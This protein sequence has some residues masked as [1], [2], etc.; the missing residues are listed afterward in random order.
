MHFRQ[1]NQVVY[2]DCCSQLYSKQEGGRRSKQAARYLSWEA[3]YRGIRGSLPATVL[4][5]LGESLTPLERTAP[6][7]AISVPLIW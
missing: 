2:R 1:Q 3:R 5:D 6:P 4:R 7:Y